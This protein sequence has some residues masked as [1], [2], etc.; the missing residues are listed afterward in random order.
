M[1][2]G[3]SG[4]SGTSIKPQSARAVAG[5]P[6]IDNTQLSKSTVLVSGRAC[7]VN[8]IFAIIIKDNAV[9]DR[10]IRALRVLRAIGL[11]PPI[12]KEH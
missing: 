10:V 5:D 3:S 12:G 4:F 1:P 8:D 6:G 2:F 9:A 11:S 7:T